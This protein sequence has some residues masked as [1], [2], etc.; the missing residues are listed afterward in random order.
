M[1]DKNKKPV[2]LVIAGH[3]PSG[4]AG[5][6]ADIE[7]IADTGCHAATIITSLTAQDTNTITGVSPQDSLFFKEQIKLIL[8]DMDV[9][10]CKIGMIGSDDLVEIIHAELSKR[11]IP[12]VLD[13]IINSETGINL[14]S[15]TTYKKIIK[16]VAAQAKLC[17]LAPQMM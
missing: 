17:I 1:K 5:I 7:S 4:G 3:D 13:P 16:I 6:Q 14:S 11:T 8:N 2:V 10:A 15:E 12:I 9:L